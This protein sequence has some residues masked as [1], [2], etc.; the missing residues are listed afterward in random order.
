MVKTTD[1]SE[2]Y[3]MRKAYCETMMS[4][5]AEDERVVAVDA[6]LVS[7]VGMAPFQKAYPERTVDCGIMEMNAA[8]VAAGMSARG[9]IPFA[10]TFSCF[11]SR[12][13][14]DQIFLSA[15]FANLNAKYVGS[16]PGIMALYNGASH[17]GLEDKGILQNVPNITIV[18]PTDA[19]MLKAILP[20]I[21]DTYG[22]FYIS[23]NRK[24]VTT[25]YDPETKFELGKGLVLKEGSDAT[26]I[27]SDIEVAEALKAADMLEDEGI[28]VSVI[29]IWT[30]KPIDEELII[31]YAKKTGCVVTAEN[32]RIRS[33]LGSAVANVLAQNYAV[34]MGM[35]GVGDVYGEVGTQDYL[36]DKF[37]LSAKCIV[38]KVKE[39]MK[40][41]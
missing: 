13:A 21:K 29:D 27:A 5:A 8:G 38:Q 25:V 30:W 22:V 35:I 12:K 4:M 10:H 23:M 32:H 34:P 24:A 7:P 26:I 33:G 31:D 17:M 15:G 11:Q 16:D 14:V 2:S 36:M 1:L 3:E 19:V 39:T 40:R 9:L 6:D 28:K 41:K 37:Q 20:Q 18:N